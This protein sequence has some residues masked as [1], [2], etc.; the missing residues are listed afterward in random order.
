MQGLSDLQFLRW[1]SMAPD[2]TCMHTI[3]PMLMALLEDVLKPRAPRLPLP[4][5]SSTDQPG[6]MDNDN[7]PAEGLRRSGSQ[8]LAGDLDS[9]LAA[10]DADADVAEAECPPLTDLLEDMWRVPE[11]EVPLAPHQGSNGDSNEQPA[12]HQDQ[13]TAWPCLPAVTAVPH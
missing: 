11:A 3:F 1:Q 2:A 5:L 9:L 8:D 6:A 4:R 13:V 12:R 7:P 10:A